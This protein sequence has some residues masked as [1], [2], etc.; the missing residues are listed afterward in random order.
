M[1]VGSS[2]KVRE[3]HHMVIFKGPEDLVSSL[4]NVVYENHTQ[5]GELM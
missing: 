5:L 3:L 4:Q 1:Q 2:V